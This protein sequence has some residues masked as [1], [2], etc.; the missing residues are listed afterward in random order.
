VLDRE[1]KV[2]GIGLSRTGTVSLA[3]ALTALGIE[4]R[5]YPHDPITQEE[6][7]APAPALTGA[8]HRVPGPGSPALDCLN[9]HPRGGAQKQPDVAGAPRQPFLAETPG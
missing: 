7:A 8:R 1:T 3:T 5:H 6:L 2:F 9:P 4:A